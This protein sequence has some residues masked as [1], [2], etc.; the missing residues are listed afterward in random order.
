[1]TTTNHTP[2]EAQRESGSVTRPA[3]WASAFVLAGMILS[4]AANVGVESRA[5]ADVSEVGDLTIASLQVA[6]G[7]EP[8]AIL[9]RRAERLF[10]YG[11]ENR[12]QIQMLASEDLRQT[13][14]RARQVASEGGR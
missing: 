7:S 6:D 3:L 5:Y 13:F 11:V 2:A 12:D 9:S 8:I 1:M 4:Q 10:I 14:A